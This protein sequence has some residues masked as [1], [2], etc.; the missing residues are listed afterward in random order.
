MDTPRFDALS[1]ALPEVPGTNVGIVAEAA[2]SAEP[3]P[4]GTNAGA[5][6]LVLLGSAVGDETEVV[7]PVSEVSGAAEAST[8]SGMSR[9]TVAPGASGPATVQLI[10]PFGIGPVQPAG[11]AVIEAPEGGV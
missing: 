2:T 8:A 9:A 10:G 7:P 4:T 3:A 5:E 11:S 1:V 6:S